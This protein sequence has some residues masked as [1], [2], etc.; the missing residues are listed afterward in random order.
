MSKTKNITG[1]SRSQAFSVAAFPLVSGRPEVQINLNKCSI[2][3][4][5]VKL[6]LRLHTGL[7]TDTFSSAAAV[8]FS[9]LKRFE[10]TYFQIS[11]CQGFLRLQ[12]HQVSCMEL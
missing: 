12:L 2:K 5:A 11:F 8:K 6:V 1:A 7:C 10:V 3:G 9:A 4:H